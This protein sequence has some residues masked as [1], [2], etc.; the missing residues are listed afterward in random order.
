MARCPP[1]LLWQ[2]LD[3][4]LDYGVVQSTST[5]AL[6][7]YVFNEPPPPPTP[8]GGGALGGMAG[9]MGAAGGLLPPGA[10]AALGVG[11]LFGQAAGAGIRAPPSAV[12]KSVL[13]ADRGSGAQRDE[14]FVDIIEKLN[15]TFNPA[16]YVLTSELDGAILASSIARALLARRQKRSPTVYESFF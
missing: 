16:G 6:K 8:A 2:L 1:S 12:Q 13:A 3:E 7:A 10:A 11:P 14:I 4:M 15:V 9:V 5:E